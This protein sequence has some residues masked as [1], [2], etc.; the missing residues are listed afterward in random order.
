MESAAG[1]RAGHDPGDLQVRVRAARDGHLEVLGD[2]AGEVAPRGTPCSSSGAFGIEGLSGRR[3]DLVFHLQLP[4]S[5]YRDSPE[6]V[7]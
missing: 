5:T 7:V 1:E 2:Q 3:L 6:L 4:G